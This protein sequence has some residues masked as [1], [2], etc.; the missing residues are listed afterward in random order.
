[1][2]KKKLKKILFF[3]GSRADYG[4]LKPLINITKADKKFKVNIMA[5]GMFIMGFPEETNQERK[6][7]GRIRNAG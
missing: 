7:P 5:T 1:M 6:Q 2:Y 4:K 3:T